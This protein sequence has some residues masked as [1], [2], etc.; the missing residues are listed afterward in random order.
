MKGI[1]KCENCKEAVL[2]K[3]SICPRCGFYEY[4]PKEL[5]RISEELKRLS[6]WRVKNPLIQH[7][8]R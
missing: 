8:V 3:Y 2:K 4:K 5:V 6:D 1:R 7:N